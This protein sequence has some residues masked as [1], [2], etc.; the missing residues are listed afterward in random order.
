[1]CRS[2]NGEKTSRFGSLFDVI[3]V[4]I[5]SATEERRRKTAIWER[6]G[7]VDETCNIILRPATNAVE[8]AKSAG[9]GT[10]WLGHPELYLSDDPEKVK[11][12]IRELEDAGWSFEWKR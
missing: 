12:G 6:Y 9:K 1:M 4:E 11:R 10:C 7:S 8:T 3:H 2:S 5:L